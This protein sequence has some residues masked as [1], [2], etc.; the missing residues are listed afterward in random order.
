MRKILD[1]LNIRQRPLGEAILRRAY[2]SADVKSAQR[3]LLD[4]ARRLDGVDRK[5]RQD[6]PGSEYLLKP[7]AFLGSLFHTVANP[8][9]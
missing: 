4:L 9:G 2:R 6:A 3:L 7:I 8:Y 5:L 1:Y